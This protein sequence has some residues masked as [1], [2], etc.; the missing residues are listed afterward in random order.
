M[1]VILNKFIKGFVRLK[2]TGSEIT[3]FFNLCMAR[4]ILLWDISEGE[5]KATG[6]INKNDLDA[7]NAVALKADVTLNVIKEYGLHYIFRNYK[8]RVM[9]FIGLFICAGLILFQSLFIWNISIGGSHSYTSEEITDYIN[10]NFDV[11]GSFKSK[12]DCEEIEK[13]LRNDYPDIAWV[14]CAISGTRLYVNI[15]ESLDVY[16]DT[17]LDTASNVVAVK[18]CTITSIVTAAGTPVVCSGDEVQAGDILI[19]GAV[20]LYDDNEEVL[21]TVYV[22]AK[23]TVYGM[24][25][26]KYN[27][28]FSMNYSTKEYTGETKSGYTLGFF[29]KYLTLC[30]GD[31][32]YEASDMQEEE[33]F[34]HIGE[35]FY[36]PLSVIKNT[37]KEY[38]L[39]YDVY[40]E[41]EA[42]Y[43][44]E[45]ALNK[46]ISDLQEKGV[47]I[48]SNNVKI[49]IEN[50]KC[51][52]AGSIKVIEPVGVSVELDTFSYD[53]IGNDEEETIE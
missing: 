40:T 47:Q 22:A 25:E 9:L 5:N 46:F 23:G 51:V 33:Y 45:S 35:D 20:Y 49:T 43:R 36:L 41:D 3:R 24:T 4:N 44:A 34:L 52:A 17:S 48:L 53:N 27:V 14:S 13:A 1:F 39:V 42:T 7:A 8:R 38:E 32:E 15:K 21:D 29:N 11:Y 50:D 30:G 2:I 12:V 28:T 6:F 19:S 18:D 31:K 37:E 16:T 10:Q 26:Y